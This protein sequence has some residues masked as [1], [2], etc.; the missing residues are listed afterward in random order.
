[1]VR[2]GAER[3]RPGRVSDRSPCSKY[4]LPFIKMALITSGCGY[5]RLPELEQRCGPPHNMDYIP[6]KWPQSPRTV[7]KCVP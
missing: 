3:A 6:T 4:G 1:M 5:I 2:A 7:V